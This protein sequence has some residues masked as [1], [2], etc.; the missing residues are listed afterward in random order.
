M[1]NGTDF[2]ATCAAD[3]VGKGS[4]FMGLM[5][6]LRNHKM[7][8]TDVYDTSK[9]VNGAGLSSGAPLFVDIGGAH[10]LDTERLLAKH[11]DLPSN[12]LIL[13][14]TPEV[15]S[16]PIEN[17]SPKITKHAYDFFTPQP[18][19]YARCYFFHAVPPSTL[20]R[21]T[22]LIRTVCECFRR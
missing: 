11:P 16:M 7:P 8:W 15:V 20:C 13:Q 18:Q 5:T 2:F 3:P 10:G 19:L 1:T 12:V 17:L 6:A 9:I 4:S 14:D 22:G 21:M